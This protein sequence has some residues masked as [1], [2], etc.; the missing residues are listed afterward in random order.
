MHII[1]QPEIWHVLLLLLVEAL[2]MQ[3]LA[4]L[5]CGQIQHQ[6]LYYA[7][8]NRLFIFPITVIVECMEHK[9]WILR[10]WFQKQQN[11]QKQ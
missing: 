1:K 6:Q 4:L 10:T 9:D 5:V 7:V 2:L 8:K 3:L 11:I